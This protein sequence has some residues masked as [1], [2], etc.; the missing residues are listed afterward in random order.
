M[1]KIRK[2]AIL[3]TLAVGLSTFQSAHAE[4]PKM[5]MTT[6]VP[7][8]ITTPDTMSSSIGS[9]NFVDGVPT[10]E[11]IQKSYDYLDRM[12]AVDVF[13]NT[14]PVASLF[15]MREGFKSQGVTGNT[16][17]I[18]DSLM[19]SKSLFL[20]ANTE[21]IYAGAWLDLS[22]GP[23]VVES[24]PNVLGIVDDFWFRYVADL[25]NAGPDQGRGGR[26]LFLPPGYDGPVPDFGF[27]VYRSKT[28]N[29][30]LIWRGFLVDND[31]GPGAESIRKHARIYPLAEIQ[32]PPKQKFVNLSG[33]P[34]N[35]V[36]ANDYTF[37]EEVNQAIQDE[38]IGSGDPELL[39][40]LAAIGIQK[41]V[42]FAPDE[43]MKAI[44]TDAAKI[45][46][47]IARALI[48]DTR[49][50][51]AYFYKDS[52]WKT[53]FI[54]GSYLF[55]HEDG[56][57]RLDARSMFFYYATMVTPA[58]ARKILGAGSQYAL[59]SEDS[60]GNPFDGA[61]SYKLTLPASVPAKDFWSMVVYDNQTRSML[62]SDQQFPSLNSNRG[63]Q[64]NKDGT[65]DIYFGP[66]VPTGKESNWIQTVPGKGWTTILRLYGPLEPWFDKT[67]RPGEIEPLN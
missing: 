52:A 53:A 32:N 60:E 62:Q 27:H 57:R 48:F 45:G 35:T 14:I 12:R 67:W 36:H 33:V 61:K 54:G 44:L 22:A 43:R 9:L 6:P 47:S 16:I 66:D 38:P 64:Q 37:Y 29:N 11:T 1:K 17:G 40:Q 28:F 4:A 30:L 18:F 50:Q 65:T 7:Q 26:F 2:T 20:T 10:E 56:S 21:S 15:A 39:G 13:L 51:E 34:F 42:P 41:D 8:A 46:N 3:T 59:A 31:P 19:D 49:D 63:V 23:I 55:E 58:M 24:P 5:K 25:G